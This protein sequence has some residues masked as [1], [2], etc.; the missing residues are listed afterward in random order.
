MS[1]YPN[2]S[3]KSRLELKLG[4]GTVYN[5]I[6]YIAYVRTYILNFSKRSKT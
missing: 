3:N 2:P 5:L 4:I 1:N 6:F